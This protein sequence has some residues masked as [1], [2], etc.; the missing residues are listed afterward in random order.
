[1]RYTCILFCF[2]ILSNV[3]A[4]SEKPAY[5]LFDKAGA[6]LAYN[7]MTEQIKES[8]IILFGEIHNNPIVHWLQYEVSKD[9]LINNGQNIVFG[10]EMFESDNQLL[11]N[12]YLKG[13]V[14]AKQLEDE[15]KM[16]NNFK[17]DYK[18]LLDL[19]AEYQV[20]F[21]ATNIPRRYAS[22]VSKKGLES[23]NSLDEDAK[24][25]ITT[26]PIVV[27]MSLPGYQNMLSM[28]GSGH[29]S[30]SN[31]SPE[32]FVKAQAA[33]DA[34]MAHF[35]L[36]NYSTGKTFIHFNG[37]YHSDDFEGIVWY[38]KKQNKELKIMTISSVEQELINELDAKSINKADFIIAIP[39]AMTKTY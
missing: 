24:K 10:A 13:L 3:Y 18:P 4:Q 6:K 34:T 8:D 14:T 29:G 33:K 36:K 32:N 25:C 16:W 35:I 17:T 2:L 37:S 22:L 27:D 1:M 19:A 11:I 28:M 7:Q 30:M 21:I 23:L 39:N 9:L 20:P 31:M 26:L 12:E 15:G 38:L 5:Q